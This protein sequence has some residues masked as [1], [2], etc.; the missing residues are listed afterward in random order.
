LEAGLA[1]LKK[2]K[3]EELIKGQGIWRCSH[4]FSFLDNLE[5]LKTI[6]KKKSMALFSSQ[7]KMDL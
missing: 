2:Q 4:Q 5:E 6:E 7:F 1:E 3:I